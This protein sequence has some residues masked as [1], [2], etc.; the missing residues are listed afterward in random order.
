PPRVVGIA[1]ALECKVTDIRPLA[2]VDGAQGR[3]TMVLGA[4]IGVYVDE[5]LL[6]EGR[7]DAANFRLLARLGYMDY[8][9]VE[10]VFELQRP[11]AD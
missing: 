1:A 8:S 10:R 11:L 5:R 4:I 2:G 3:Y 6:K 7:V 9:V